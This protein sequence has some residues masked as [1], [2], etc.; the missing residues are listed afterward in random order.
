MAATIGVQRACVT[1]AARRMEPED[2]DDHRRGVALSW[3]ELN[4]VFARCY[5]SEI[6]AVIDNG[7]ALRVGV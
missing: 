6:R 2:S 4:L 5:A 3:D 7:V 1:R